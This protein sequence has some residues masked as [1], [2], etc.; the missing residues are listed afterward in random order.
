MIL[1]A[2]GGFGTKRDGRRMVLCY[3][4]AMEITDRNLDKFKAWLLERGRTEGTADAYVTN[5]RSCA[6]DR[7]GLTHRLVGD[8]LAPNTLRANLAA[9]RAWALYIDDPNLAKRLGDILLPPARRVHTKQPLPAVSLRHL[10]KHLKICRMPSE[11]MRQVLLIMAI[12]GFRSGDVLRLRRAEI[13]RA[14]DT[15]KLVYEA[16][17]RKRLEFAAEPL[18]AQ[19]EALVQIKDWDRVRDLIARSQDPKVASVKVWRTARR[20]ASEIGIAGMSPHRFRHTFATRYLEQLRGDPNAIIK[21]QKFMGWESMN[22]AARYVDALSQ[23]ELDAIGAG[24]VSGL[25]D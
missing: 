20:A 3:S 13:L 1:V 17:G 8:K 16:K 24:L 10:I 15:G 5:L 19:L 9:L 4:G 22:T 14:L 23:D 18:R 7:K 2:Q 6:A 25:L 21:L 12:R 11:A